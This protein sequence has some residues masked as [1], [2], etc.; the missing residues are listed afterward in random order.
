VVSASELIV[1]PLL[2]VLKLRPEDGLERKTTSLSSTSMTESLFRLLRL[3]VVP[4]L[5]I[6]C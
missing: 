5:K 4:V 3:P 6:K 1:V 2:T